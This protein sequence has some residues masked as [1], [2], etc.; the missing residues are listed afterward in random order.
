MDKMRAEH[1]K[2][3]ADSNRQAQIDAANLS[4]KAEARKEAIKRNELKYARTI[5]DH[6]K[7]RESRLQ[8]QNAIETKLRH[9]INKQKAKNISLWQKN[10][11]EVKVKNKELKA[12]RRHFHQQM[13][14]NNE[15]TVVI[16]EIDD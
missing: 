3:I 14:N 15:Q 1:K 8:Q 10:T 13:K 6:Q 11:A 4:K 2:K 9:Q 12:Q 16:E 7:K 5:H